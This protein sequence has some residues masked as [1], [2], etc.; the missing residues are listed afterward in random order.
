MKKILEKITN[1]FGY[2]V[3]KNSKYLLQN[4]NPMKAISSNFK[5]K[6]A[7]FFDIGVNQG[8]TTKKMK[9]LFPQSII[10]GFEPSKICFKYLMDNVNIEK[11]FFYNKA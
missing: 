1:A 9:S 10:Y 4:D 6:D 3:S 11:V 7:V 8:Q 5:D 2:K